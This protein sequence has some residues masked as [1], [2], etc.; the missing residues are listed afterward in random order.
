MGHFINPS[1]YDDTR[2]IL[3]S[4]RNNDQIKRV[5][6]I[7]GTVTNN[8]L[9]INVGGAKISAL[10]VS[11]YN[12]V[13]FLGIANGRIYK[14]ANASTATPTLTRIDTFT[15]NAGWVSSI[16]VGGSDDTIL[17]TFSNYGVTSV[18]ETAN[19]G[20]TWRNKE[21]NLPDMPIRW[22]L[23]NP[24]NRNQVV[25]ATEVGVWST[26]NFA[27]GAAGTPVW[28]VSSSSLAHT[29]CDMLQYRAADKM[30]V[31]ATHG[32]GLF[33]S[34]IFVTSRVV[35]FSYSPFRS[36]TGSLT[37]NFTDGSLKPNGLWAWDVNN[38]GMTDYT[39]QNPTHTY[40]TTGDYQVKLYI[41]NDIK[42]WDEKT[43]S[44]VVSNLSTTQ[45]RITNFSVVPN[46]TKA[47]IAINWNNN[48]TNIK[49]QIYDV[50]GKLISEEQLHNKGE[51]ISLGSFN[52]GLYFLK[53][54]TENSIQIIKIVK[55]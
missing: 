10:K 35:D 11:P 15:A 28:G 29:R 37:V 17:I 3:Y 16:D 24:N 4:A 45:N 52:C 21:G 51:T 1:D 43:E 27:T 32:R 46:P 23:Y 30:L 13:V 36:C 50:L 22:A 39:T 20:L 40:A 8:N 6:N 55:E 14:Y 2:N 41:E 53:I 49:Y 48:Y 47:D 25:A 18:W 31:V 44:V 19:G 34:D 5:S 26:D 33:T 54:S 7:T 12:D 9:A 42:S 38:D